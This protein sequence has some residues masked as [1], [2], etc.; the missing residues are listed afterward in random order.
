MFTFHFASISCK[1][2]SCFAY[3]AVAMGLRIQLFGTFQLWRDGELLPPQAWKRRKTQTLLK[4]LLLERGQIFTQE[5]LVE[6]LFPDAH[7]FKSLQNLHGR[8]SE[9]RKLLEPDLMK[10]TD[11]I[12]ILSPS[13]GNYQFNSQI[14]C[15]IDAEVFQEQFDQGDV[16]LTDQDWISA[17]QCFQ[18]AIDFYQGGYLQ[19]DRYED[20]AIP[21]HQQ[22]Q[23]RY[24]DTLIKLAECS[25]AQSHY[26]QAISLIDRGLQLDTSREQLYRT[27]MQ[28]YAHLGELG[29]VSKVYQRCVQVLEDELEVQPAFQTEQLYQ[30]LLDHESRL[31]SI[32]VLPFLQL[33]TRQEHTYFSDGLTD[34]VI[35]QLSKISDLKVISRT[36]VMRYKNTTKS[37]KA[38][39]QEL[40]VNTILEGS[41]RVHENQVRIVAQLID[42]TTDDHLWTDTYDRDMTDIFS[43]QSDVAQQIGIALKA[44]VSSSERQRIERKP[45]ES[46]EAYQFYLKG[47]YLWNKRHKDELLKAVDFFE[48]AIELDENYALA[49]TG[50]ADT[51]TILGWFDFAPSVEMFPKALSAAQR[52]LELDDSLA[53]AYAALGYVTMNHC[54]DWVNAE[55]HL[56]RALEINPNYATGHHWYGEYFS[57]TGQHDKAIAELKRALELDPLSLVI[58]TV[59]AWKLCYAD[60]LDEAYDQC[61]KTLE[62]DGQ[63]GP[64]LTVLGLICERRGEYEKA[65]EYFQAEID[66][67]G[68]TIP[69]KTSMAYTYAVSG[70]HE[71]AYHLLEELKNP[72]L[73]NV[74]P[75]H[76]GSVYSGLGEIDQA[77][78]W[79][80]RAYDQH[81]WVL[82]Y[83]KNAHRLSLLRQDP[84][85]D[86]LLK[87]M[88]LAD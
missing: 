21:H 68:K 1:E 49:Y 72:D 34:D 51:L 48:Q 88:G 13:K 24:L 17:S 40:G 4:I 57:I 77:F 56:Q 82:I 26:Q 14:E 65:I 71:Q 16:F 37:I 53:E 30:Q 70:Q 15:E 32:A 58:N 11:S 75:Y 66:I 61:Q 76:I 22:W 78:E 25:M 46:L 67:M 31:K 87:R 79:F 29:E 86:N 45:T 85:Y 44:T 7:P 43:I 50:L 60:R 12:F 80:E 28:C 27:L 41:V 8:M 6:W 81:Q 5:Q 64:A 35:S 19:E 63:F 2:A 9:L 36:S 47:R 18:Q 84:H 3:N 55:K 52:A 33:S 74:S 23:Y 20:W 39:G 10:G 69:N 83:L 54:W 42:A 59:L 38:I 62:L 73:N